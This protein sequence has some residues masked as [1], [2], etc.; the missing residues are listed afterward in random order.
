MSVATPPP[1]PA[2]ERPEVIAS[3]MERLLN[4]NA[5]ENN[6]PLGLRPRVR[7]LPD[8]RRDNGNLVFE[9]SVTGEAYGGP[10]AIQKEVTHDDLADRRWAAG[11]FRIAVMDVLRRVSRRMD[12]E[13]KARDE[14]E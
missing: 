5:D 3:K 14:E 6:A 9:V 1:P 11:P 12:A 7:F 4:E 10:I 2:G 13:R 8:E